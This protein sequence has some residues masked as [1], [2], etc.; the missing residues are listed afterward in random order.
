MNRRAAGSAGLT[1]SVSAKEQ[2][3][4]N[5]LEWLRALE[6]CAAPEQQAGATASRASSCQAHPAPTRVASEPERP[7]SYHGIR[8][9]QACNG[10]AARTRQN[11]R[12]AR[13]TPP[14]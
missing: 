1:P 13:Q 5:P 2:N 4:L 10:M 7:R 8:I 11:G 14:T 9:C 3:F 6:N 12:G